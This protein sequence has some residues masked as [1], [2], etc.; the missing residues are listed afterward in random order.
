MSFLG[1]CP[2]LGVCCHLWILG[3]RDDY[4]LPGS[5]CSGTLPQCGG[6]GEKTER[7]FRKEPKGILFT[8][9]GS[10]HGKL[11]GVVGRG[12]LSNRLQ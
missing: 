2:F 1:E 8:H 9:R 4:A 5:V 3:K 10:V 12:D 6:L 11:G 7:T